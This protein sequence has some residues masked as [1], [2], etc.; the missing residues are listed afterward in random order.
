[1]RYDD[2]VDEPA[3]AV[4]EMLRTVREG[5]I[6]NIGAAHRSRDGSSIDVLVS[7]SMMEYEGSPAILS[8]NRDVTDT[9][10]AEK[11]I[12]QLAYQDPLTGLANRLRFEDRL[13]VAL[14]SARREQQALAV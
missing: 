14:A 1:M 10:R 9:K 6:R 5:S 8:I 4:A 13:G 12:E 3:G 7:A 2:L 11:Q